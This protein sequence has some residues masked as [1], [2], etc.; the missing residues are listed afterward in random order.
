MQLHNCHNGYSFH[1][2]GH[3]ERKPCLMT[4]SRDSQLAATSLSGSASQLD[5]KLTFMDTISSSVAYPFTYCKAILV[6]ML[7][8][9]RGIL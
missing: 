7:Q 9:G 1:T 6:Q 5:K 4:D 3:T 2:E 8:R